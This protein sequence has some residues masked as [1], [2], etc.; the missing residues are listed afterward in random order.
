M[1]LS[2]P[3]MGNG[4]CFSRDVISRYGWNAYSLTENWEYYANLVLDGYVPTYAE[5]ALIYSHM[6]VKLAHGETQRKRWITGRIQTSS[7]YVPRLLAEFMKRKKAIPL[8]AAVEFLLP[9]LSMLFNWSI[10]SLILALVLHSAGL[11]LSK[12]LIAVQA[13]VVAVQVLFFAA[14]LLMSRAP[15]QTW[16]SLPLIPI[17]L[18]W[19]LLVTA[20]AVLGIRRKA[21]WE[22]T[23]RITKL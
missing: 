15:L 3:L 23:K 6:V 17:I 8:D 4:M 13:G 18:I 7:K 16:I 19:R 22:K 11:V 5:K 10:L 20:K 2:C 14:G 12:S 9:S 1:G 21:G